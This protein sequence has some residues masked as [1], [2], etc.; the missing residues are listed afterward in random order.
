LSRCIGK[1]HCHATS[2]AKA[3]KTNLKLGKWFDINYFF[4]PKHDDNKSIHH[5][6]KI[7]TISDNICLF[8]YFAPAVQQLL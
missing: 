8:A 2:D 5:D 3:R 6:I 4:A 7:V 1:P